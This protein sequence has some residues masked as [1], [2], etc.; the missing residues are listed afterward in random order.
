MAT[1][2]VEVANLGGGAATVT[3]DYNDVTLLVT[4]I[5]GRNDSVDGKTLRIDVTSPKVF[6]R[7]VLAGQVVDQTLVGANRI[8][9]VDSADYHGNIRHAGIDWNATLGV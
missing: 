1:A 8:P 9:Y 5:L 4:R 3:Y 6:S 7:T 2:T